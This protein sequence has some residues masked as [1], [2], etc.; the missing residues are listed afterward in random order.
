MQETSLT[1]PFT[2]A[3]EW[4]R[5][6][7]Y[8]SIFLV[9]GVKFMV[10]V[11][12]SLAKGLSFW[13]QFLCTTAGGIGGSVFFTYLG[14]AVRGW[15]SKLRGRPPKPLSPRWM[16]FW[17]RYGLWG[18]VL[19]TPPILSP[20]IGTAIALAFRTPRGI[21]AWRLTIAMVLWGIVFAA[22]GEGLRS[23]IQILGG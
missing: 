17:E 16:R 8:L 5:I 1:A 13:E 22:F 15:I 2:M 10:G 6:L 7:L 11:A 19:L 3:E 9:S 14:D 23:L 21:L 18:V 12:M 20:P 4:G